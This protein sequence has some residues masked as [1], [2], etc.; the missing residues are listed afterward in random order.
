MAAG[1]ALPSTVVIAVLVVPAGLLAGT[2]TFLLLDAR[3][4]PK[5][6]TRPT[7]RLGAL[8]HQDVAGEAEAWLR[9]H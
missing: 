6:T 4:C 8:T 3:R 7:W 9:E 5:Q 2:G 1:A